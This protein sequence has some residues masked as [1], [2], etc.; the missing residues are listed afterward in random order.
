VI[1]RYTARLLKLLDPVEVAELPPAADDWYANLIWIDRRKCLLAVHADTLFSI[2]IADVRKPDLSDFGGYLAGSI[3]TALADERLAPNCLGQLDPAA[4][5]V[6]PTASRS[7]LGFMNDMAIMSKVY[8]AQAGGIALL[9]V[10]EL[11]AHLRR[12]PY[13]RDVYFRPIDATRER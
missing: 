11:N 2:F 3:A 6:A 8:A 12:T 4:V 7:V 9:D 13:K 10:D 5:Q 1:V